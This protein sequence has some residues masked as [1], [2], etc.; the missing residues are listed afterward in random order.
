MNH[1]RDLTLPES[2]QAGEIYQHLAV[3]LKTRWKRYRKK[4]KQCQR[5]FSEDA[6]HN[7]RIET[8]RLLSLVEMLG[9]LLPASHLKKA[10]RILKHHLD[11]F[12]DLRDTHVQLLFVKPM[13]RS[14]P[15][16]RSF[17]LALC[18]REQRCAKQTAKA[19]EHIKTA[20][21]RRLIEALHEELCEKGKGASRRASG[22]EPV[23]RAID[24][25]YA[26][27][28][29]RRER[30]DSSDTVTIHR[31]R[32]A[33]KKFRYM[34]EALAPLLPDVSDEQLECM[35][36]YQA[37]MG[38]IQDTEVLLAALDKFLRKGKIGPA[39]GERFREELMRRRQWLID[40]FLDEADRLDGFWPL[41]RL[42]GR[43]VMPAKKRT[44]K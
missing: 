18:K 41:A 9:A 13:L 7:S 37:M 34:V 17:Y 6:V 12:D 20:R 2:A 30:I 35:Q 21:L 4:L 26:A 40:V 16:V 36:E 14:F 24:R 11:T 1:T 44:M 19:I 38:D 39:A 43:G 42:A 23:M 22:L 32:I 25:A 5:K 3:S 31:T 8:R 28:R 33:F 29:K 27:V 15:A 10:R